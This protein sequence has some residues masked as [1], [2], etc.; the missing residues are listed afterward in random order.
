MRVIS[1]GLLAS[2]MAATSGS[3]MAAAAAPSAADMQWT[4]HGRDGNEQRYSP[5]KQVNVDNVKEL[6]LA[7]TAD[8]P[9]KSSWQGTPIVVGDTMYVTTPWS[10][11]YAYNA[12]TGELKFKYS[13]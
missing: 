3:A 9:E 13:A 11:L 8:M 2:V 1:L 4:E 10:N 7:W 12:K 6:G 5:L